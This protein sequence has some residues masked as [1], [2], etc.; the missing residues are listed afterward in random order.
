MVRPPRT[1]PD[2]CID[3]A[4]QQAELQEAN[5]GV[6]RLH[7]L[8]R[9]GDVLVAIASHSMPPI[10]ASTSKRAKSGGRWTWHGM[11]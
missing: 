11:A 3:N 9:Q 10:A 6:I 1:P 8:Q 5:G 4:G 2:A 7:G